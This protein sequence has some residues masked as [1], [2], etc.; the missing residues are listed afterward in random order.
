VIERLAAEFARHQQAEITKRPRLADQRRREFA[1]LV[2]SGRI[3][4]DAIEGECH[5]VGLPCRLFGGQLEMHGQ[6]VRLQGPALRR[7]GI[8]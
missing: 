6:F 2:D 5:S 3:G 8:R 1:E 4:R 7:R